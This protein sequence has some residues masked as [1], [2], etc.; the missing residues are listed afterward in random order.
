M[1]LHN[2]GVVTAGGKEFKGAEA[3]PLFRKAGL[4]V[5][6]RRVTDGE[7]RFAEPPPLSD[8]ATQISQFSG[9][10]IRARKQ[11][12]APGGLERI[13]GVRQD[14]GQ[15]I[16]NEYDEDCGGVVFAVSSIDGSVAGRRLANADDLTSF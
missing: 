15:E 7:S 13:P 2:K 8:F 9:R 11:Q 1:G 14:P 10:P 12:G 16:E 6:G 3:S 4:R 5:M